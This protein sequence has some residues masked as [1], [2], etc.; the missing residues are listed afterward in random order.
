MWGKKNKGTT[1]CHKK[2]IKCDIGIA[3]CDNGNRQ[4]W[5]KK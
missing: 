1:I 2:T 3:Q 4:I 5:E